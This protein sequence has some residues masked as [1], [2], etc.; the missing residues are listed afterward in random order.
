MEPSKN[1][2]I[3]KY[4]RKIEDLAFYPFFNLPRV[5]RIKTAKVFKERQKQDKK[6]QKSDNL[7]D[8]N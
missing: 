2:N 6:E 8:E 3:S 1:I 4:I 7:F 5:Q